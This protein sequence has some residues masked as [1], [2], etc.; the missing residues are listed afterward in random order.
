MNANNTGAIFAN[1]IV[2]PGIEAPENPPSSALFIAG[3]DMFSD[4]PFNQRADKYLL[5]RNRPRSHWI[6]WVGYYDDVNRHDCLGDR[7]DYF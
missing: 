4:S 6:L 3:V 1:F 2:P 7:H 5:S